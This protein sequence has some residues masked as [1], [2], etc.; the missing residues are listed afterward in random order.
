MKKLSKLHIGLIVALVAVLAVGVYFMFSYRGAEAKQPDIQQEIDMAQQRLDILR[1]SDD[2]DEPLKE[3]LDELKDQIRILSMGEPL[4]PE[5]PAT[6][7]IG[8]LVVDTIHNLDPTQSGA[9]VLLKLNS[10]DKAGTVIIKSS[11]DPEDQGN[12]YN[13]AEYEVK[14]QGD[15]GRINSLI[16]EIE[17]ADFATLVIEDMVIEYEE[18]EMDMGFIKSWWE[19]EFTIVTLY[20]YEEE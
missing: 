19:A 13:K 17:G 4:F 3:Q 5:L 20:Q 11:T 14:V 1:N 16:G 10:D 12:K 6:V 18:E 2:E 7:E 15:L 9:L 8:D